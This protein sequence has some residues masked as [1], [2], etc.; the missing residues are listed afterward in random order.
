M[1]RQ[2]VGLFPGLVPE[3]LLRGHSYHRSFFSFDAAGSTGSRE[4]LEDP[5]D[6]KAPMR[7]KQLGP[8]PSCT[9]HLIL[10]KEARTPIYQDRNGCRSQKDWLMS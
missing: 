3:N 5:E 7:G 1:R 2:V 10:I 8:K 4:G 6:G 9:L